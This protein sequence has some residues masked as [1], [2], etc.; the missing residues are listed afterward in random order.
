MVEFR[1]LLKN[2]CVPLCVGLMVGGLLGGFIHHEMCF[3]LPM[4]LADEAIKASW[5]HDS[6]GLPGDRFWT[7]V[8]MLEL[9]PGD[10]CS[11]SFCKIRERA[12]LDGGA[13]LAFDE[14]AARQKGEILKDQTLPYVLTTTT[15]KR[16][17]ADH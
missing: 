9:I 17:E 14:S 11:K 12:R 7:I 1:R 10:T 3:G 13:A 4:Y 15:V 8:G 16:G 5:P 2:H 6:H